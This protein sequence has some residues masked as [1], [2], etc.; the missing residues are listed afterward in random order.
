[1][2]MTKFIPNLVDLFF[3]ILN[4]IF[5]LLETICNLKFKQDL[6]S[7]SKKKRSR[8]VMVFQHAIIEYNL[9]KKN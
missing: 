9:V 4:F 3:I 5:L 8:I 6:L 2:R 7:F 1:M